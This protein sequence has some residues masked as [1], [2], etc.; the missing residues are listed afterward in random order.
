MQGRRFHN[1]LAIALTLSALS[2]G[3]YA[4]DKLSK[5]PEPVAAAGAATPPPTETGVVNA[6]TKVTPLPPLQSF[7]EITARPLFS[8]TRRPPVPQKIQRS[9]P[10]IASAPASQKAKTGQY[11]L[12]GV[13]IDEKTKAALLRKGRKGEP[14]Q[15]KIGQN[16]DGWTVEDIVAGSVKLRQGEVV[17]L[18]LLR[19][20]V[21][22]RGERR[23][24]KHLQGRAARKKNL[25]RKKLL[26]R[27]ARRMRSN[28]NRLEQSRRGF[29][30]GKPV[31]GGRAAPRRRIAAPPNMKVK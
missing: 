30:P 21:L 28:L 5:P 7:S 22:S 8:A 12:I 9:K 16:L 3:A 17:D 10:V 14:T 20:N 13:I 19:D 27:K 24:L 23:K 2:L 4:Y 1:L 18:V 29:V 25:A 26:S 6:P 11:T 15:V 31:K